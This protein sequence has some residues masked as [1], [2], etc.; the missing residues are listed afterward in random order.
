MKVLRLGRS[1][2]H[3]AARLRSLQ[4]PDAG[5]SLA[6]RS[7]TPNCYTTRRRL[8]LI[9]DDQKRKETSKS[10]AYIVTAGRRYRKDRPAFRPARS[11]RASRAITE[12]ISLSLAA[13]S[14]SKMLSSSSSKAMEHLNTLLAWCIPPAGARPHHTIPS[15][16]IAL[17]LPVPLLWLIAHLFLT[18]PKQRAPRL[19]LLPLAA[20]L[21]L[22]SGYFARFDPEWGQHFNQALGCYAA[23]NGGR[24]LWWSFQTKQYSLRK[25]FESRVSG[26]SFVEASLFAPVQCSR[27]RLALH[28]GLLLSS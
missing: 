19:A 8:R 24:A 20:A 9:V 27:R 11:G 2:E 22:R 14:E 7:F 18:Y 28:S 10:R 26:I 5:L 12:C 4:P 16:F 17:V 21:S 25:G 3:F 13:P 1:R 6:F 23:W 15:V